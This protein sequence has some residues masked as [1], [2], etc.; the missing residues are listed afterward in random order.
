MKNRYPHTLENPLLQS[1]QPPANLNCIQIFAYPAY[2]VS[3]PLKPS[4]VQSS[5]PKRM[6]P[7]T[8]N[9][10]TSTKLYLVLDFI[11]GGHLFFNL[12]REVGCQQGGNVSSLFCTYTLHRLCANLIFCL[13]CVHACKGISL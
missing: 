5:K 12:Y 2:R 1:L 11:N 7:S 4:C 8:F 9:P 13:R 3:N 10:Q 6:L